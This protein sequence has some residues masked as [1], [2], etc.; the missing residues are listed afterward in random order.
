MTIANTDSA[1]VMIVGAAVTDNSTANVISIDLV[2]GS[3]IWKYRIDEGK[4]KDG[5]TSGQ[6]PLLIGPDGRPV[7]VLTTYQNGVWALTQ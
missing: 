3:Q 7:V 1:P 2:N 6:F 5:W 4:G